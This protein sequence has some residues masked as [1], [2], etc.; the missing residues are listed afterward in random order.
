[1]DWDAADAIGKVSGAIAVVLTL[2][3][4]SAQIRQN[5]KAVKASAVAF[6]RPGTSGIDRPM[7]E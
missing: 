1:M 4:L 7:A 2:I 3:Y 6:Q 5:A